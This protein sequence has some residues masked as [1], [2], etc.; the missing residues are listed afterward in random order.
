MY[1]RLLA[2]FTVSVHIAFIAFAVL[3]GI[4]VLRWPRLIIIHLPAFVWAAYVELSGRICPLTPLENHF[5][6]LAGEAGYG[7]G[8]IEQ[9]ALPL[10]YPGDLTLKL[11]VIL[12]GAVVVVNLAIYAL[13][14]N[15]RFLRSRFGEAIRKPSR[16]QSRRS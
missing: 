11:Q 16:A 8:F 6:I 1:F 4:L 14:V 2:E 12:G 9:Y 10:I 3:G 13:I 7:R 15:H 5:R